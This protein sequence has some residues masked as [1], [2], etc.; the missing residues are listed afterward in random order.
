MKV[1][2]WICEKTNH[3]VRTPTKPANLFPVTNA[4]KNLLNENMTFG[5]YDDE[6]VTE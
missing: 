1:I 3:N 5:D 2:I 4:I 6:S